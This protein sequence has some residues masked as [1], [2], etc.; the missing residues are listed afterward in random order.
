MAATFSYYNTAAAEIF[1][2]GIS[3][4]D[5]LKAILL[6]DAAVFDA[7]D[8]LLADVIGAS[9]ENEVYGLGWPQ[10]GYTL[11]TLAVATVNTNDAKLS[12]ADVGQLITGGDLDP[13][14]AYLLVGEIA[15]D[16]VTTILI[17]FI[18]LDTPQTVLENQ[19][20][21][22]PWDPLGVIHINII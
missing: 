17:A 19:L 13:V 20:A 5:S 12:A 1:F 16:P 14:Y 7:T 8:T 2:R 10:G 3:G 22:I 6:N 15:G 18:T 4:F 11:Q 21:A 9:G